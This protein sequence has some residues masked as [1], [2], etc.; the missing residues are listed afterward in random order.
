[1]FFVDGE[2]GLAH[3]L[4]DLVVVFDFLFLQQ[5]LVGNRYR[6]LRFNLQELVVHVEDDLLDH[7]FGFLG[8]VDQVVEVGPD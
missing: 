7:L 1:M 5:V 8:F 4:F 2:F 6:Y 3:P